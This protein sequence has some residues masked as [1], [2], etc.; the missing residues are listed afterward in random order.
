M[1]AEHEENKPSMIQHNTVV[2][3]LRI[4]M[5]VYNYGKNIV[6]ED[7][8]QTVETFVGK[9]R[10]AG[11]LETMK[12]SDARKEALSEIAEHAPSGKVHKF[13]S[14]PTTDLQVGITTNDDD[15]RICVVF[16]GS[17]SKSDWYYDLQIRK[18]HIRDGIYVHGGFYDQLYG[19]DVCKK[20]IDE[21][22]QLVEA[23]PDYQIY[24]TGHSLG[25][26]LSTLFGF[27]LS[28]EVDNA[29]T[30][31]S[32]AS[33]RVGNMEWRKAFEAKSNLTHYRIANNRDVVTAFPMYKYKHVG[34]NIRLFEDTFA[35]F[36]N[37]SYNTWYDYSLFRCWSISDHDCDLYYKRLLKN[38]W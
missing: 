1:I 15:K 14:E 3:L 32:F 8:N 13:I 9:M 26:A 4:T 30:V 29:I 34:E 24:I 5:L 7:E 25:A 6:M 36:S 12:V 37:Y 31:V 18:R 22:K 23:N 27:L 11:T 38:K 19:N 35:V 2:D 33:P 16:R 20:L 10:E 21:M 28:H 17:E